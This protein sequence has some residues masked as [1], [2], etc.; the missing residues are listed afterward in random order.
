MATETISRIIL[1]D[2]LVD[3]AKVKTVNGI[4][5]AKVKSIWGIQ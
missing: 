2:H 1:K 5:T 3:I 4:N